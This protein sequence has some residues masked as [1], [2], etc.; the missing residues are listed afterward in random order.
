M[1]EYILYYLPYAGA[2]AS[3]FKRWKSIISPKIKFK[4]IEYSGHGKRNKEDFYTSYKEACEDIYKIIKVDNKE[5]LPFFLAGHCLGALL[6]VEMYYFLKD[7]DELDLLKGIIVSGHGAP[8]KI[9]NEHMETMNNE[10]LG[11]YLLKEGAIKK[12][13]LEVDMKPFFQDLILPPIKADA[14]LYNEYSFKKDR[15][16]IGVDLVIMSGAKDWKCPVSEINRWKEFVDRTILY[17]IYDSDHYFINNL[18]E[19]CVNDINDII[20]ETEW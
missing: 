1:A 12:E 9:V 16:K 11:E 17:F 7:K 14:K 2:S 5:N 8:D 18:R 3:T 13:M 19:E 6:A 20:L 10:E 15:D 4:V